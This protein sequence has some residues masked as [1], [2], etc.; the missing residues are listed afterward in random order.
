MFNRRY[1]LMAV[2][3]LFYRA[4]LLMFNE[5]TALISKNL[6]HDQTR[7]NEMKRE[8]V[9]Q[10]LK[11]RA[12]FLHF[13]NYW[14]FSELANKDEESQHFEMMSREYRIAEIMTE[15]EKELEAMS[16]S[17]TEFFQARNT[18]AVN[19]L[20]MLSLIFGAG[21]IV[22]GYFGMN[23]GESF[24]STFFSPGT[25]GEYIIHGLAVTVVSLFALG[26]L[27]FGLYVIFANWRDYGHILAPR[28]KPLK[29]EL[30]LQSAAVPEGPRSFVEDSDLSAL[31][32]QP[33]EPTQQAEKP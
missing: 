27:M 28:H 1:Y 15:L 19:R 2:V 6:Y 32:P 3:A 16:I 17:T 31:H 25:P 4:T 20:A 10:A 33:C 12:E 9:E 11:L 24:G 13:S 30:L 7:S 21:A 26:A 22:T 5:K 8:N 29:A 23:F 14:Y 18:A